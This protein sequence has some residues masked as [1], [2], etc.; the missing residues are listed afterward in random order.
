MSV[1]PEQPGVSPDTGTPGAVT[2][3]PADAAREGRGGWPRFAVAALWGVGLLGLAARLVLAWYSVGSNDMT[4]WAFFTVLIEQRGVGWMYDNV[5]A[6]NHPPL[7]GYLAW[8]TLWLANATGWP[9]HFCFKLPQVLAEAVVVWLLWK[10]WSRGGSPLR[11]AAA[12]ALFGWSLDSILLAAYH[13]NTDALVALMCLLACY[14]V[15]AH[16]L[17]FLGGLALGGAIN[18]KLIPVFL[19]PP[20]LAGCRGRELL[21][22]MGGLALGAVP[23]VPFLLDH[24]Q[25]FYRNALTY[26]S[27]FDNWGL[28]F[29]IR[30][31]GER[32]PSA[33]AERVRELFVATGR[34]LNLGLI[35]AVSLWARWRGKGGRYELAAICLSL[36]LIFT[37]GFGVQY[38][39]YICPLLF[40]V[41]LRWAAAY[42]TLAGVFVGWVYYL[43]W[44]HGVP[45]YSQFTS[46]LQFEP[47]LVGF[48]AWW[49]LIGFVGTRLRA[50]GLLRWGP[51]PVVVPER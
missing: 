5:Q 50:L 15:E 20:L 33:T 11:A 23:F 28:P 27:N 24:G 10:R 7:M 9:F 8:G 13:G 36:F 35:L 38:T 43:F 40:A 19:V 39:V 31:W 3:R 44:N 42:A 2:A 34:Y 21:R 12:V 18:V 16:G 49:V 46:A 51:A 32:A 6:F 30:Q 48:C 45:A 22:F 47:A 37:P 41:S 17:F 25:T 1:S 26:N 4:T 29:L 14:L